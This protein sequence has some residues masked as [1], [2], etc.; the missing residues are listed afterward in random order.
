MICIPFPHGSRSG[1]AAINDYND[2]SKFNGDLAVAL[3]PGNLLT[4]DLQ[5]KFSGGGDASRRVASQPRSISVSGGADHSASDNYEN[6]GENQP[7]GWSRSTNVNYAT[8]PALR[9]NFVPARIRIRLSP[10]VSRPISPGFRNHAGGGRRG[11][12][13]SPSGVKHS[14]R[15]YIRNTG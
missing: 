1:R 8:V 14:F 4:I 13:H 3:R 9:E 7:I 6:R 15:T 10:T 2:R 12:E 5:C 11:D